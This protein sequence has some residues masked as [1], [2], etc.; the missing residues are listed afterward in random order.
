[1]KRGATST[2]KFVLPIPTDGLK[3][4]QIT[5]SQNG[6]IVLQKK[7]AEIRTDGYELTTVITQ[8]QSFLF[9]S[10]SYVDIQVRVLTIDDVAFASQP[11]RTTVSVSLDN[12][13]LI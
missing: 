13:V 3:T 5:Y 6:K 2:H 1:M 4:I 8:A 10:R 11:M 7:N 9:D 12:E